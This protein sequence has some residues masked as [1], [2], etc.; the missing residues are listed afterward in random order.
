MSDRALIVCSVADPLISLIAR[1]STSRIAGG[2][3]LLTY[4]RLKQLRQI[5]DVMIRNSA[6][7]PY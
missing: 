6:V 4:K 3:E 5:R 2:K 1:W 7:K